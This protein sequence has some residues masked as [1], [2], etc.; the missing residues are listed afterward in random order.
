MQHSAKAERTHQF[1]RGIAVA[2]LHV[3]IVQRGKALDASGRVVFQNGKII[4]C[5]AFVQYQPAG[6][7]IRFKN[8]LAVIFAGG[9]C[10]Q[11]RH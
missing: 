7:L 11:V 5:R 3:Q 8:Q 4:V 2:A 9:L 6:D 10:D 1:M